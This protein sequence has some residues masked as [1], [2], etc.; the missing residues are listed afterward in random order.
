MGLNGLVAITRQRASHKT[1]YA[2]LATLITQWLRIYISLLPRGFFIIYT[3]LR[4]EA[5]EAFKATTRTI[6]MLDVKVQRCLNFA[7]AL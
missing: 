5:K 1:F 4:I 6:I 2:P 7:F 3:L